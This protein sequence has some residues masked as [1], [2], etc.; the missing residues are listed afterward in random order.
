MIPLTRPL[1]LFQAMVRHVF[2]VKFEILVVRISMMLHRLKF[3]LGLL[4]VYETFERMDL[5]YCF[6]LAVI[7][8]KNQSIIIN[9][10]RIH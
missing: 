1:I 5:R 9:S 8:E 7:Y 6:G 10:Y 2:S 4:P 3:L